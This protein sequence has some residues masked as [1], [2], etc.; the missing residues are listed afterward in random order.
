MRLAEVD[1]SSKDVAAQLSE[2][3]SGPVEVCYGTHSQHSAAVRVKFTRRSRGMLELL[4][5]RECQTFQFLRNRNAPSRNRLVALAL[6]ITSS[7]I[8]RPRA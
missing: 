4:D 3:Q 7:A 8:F 6:A 1:D 2:S 5:L